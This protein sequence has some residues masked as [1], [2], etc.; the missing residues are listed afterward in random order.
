MTYV[1]FIEL[2]KNK[3]IKVGSLG[4]VTFKKGYYFYIGSARK[5]ADRRIRRHLSKN[6]CR[7][8]HIDYL[9]LSNNVR[10]KG[11]WLSNKNREC[12]TAGYLNKKVNSFIEGFGSSDCNCQSHLFFADNL[13]TIQTLLDKS[14]FKDTNKDSF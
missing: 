12:K 6:K 14:G 7:F 1:L 10:I 4:D 13:I 9:L 5:W 2:E 11:I 3:R 8:W